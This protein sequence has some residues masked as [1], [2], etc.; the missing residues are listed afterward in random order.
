MD[1]EIK[2]EVE[3]FHRILVAW[4][5]GAVPRTEDAYAGISGVL[6][7][8]FAL[9][10]PRGGLAE[11]KGLIAG[12]ESAHGAHSGA[13]KDFSIRIENCVARF[14]GDNL[15]VATYEAWEQLSGVTTAR[16]C[17]CVFRR[18]PHMRHGLEWVHLHETWLKDHAPA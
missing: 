17:T 1:A 4:F 7:D 9:V 8:D 3:E 10:S 13:A 2:A 5:T 6:S 15:C 18:N 12:M 14:A 16:L 11:G